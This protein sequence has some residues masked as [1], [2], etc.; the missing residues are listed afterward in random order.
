[1]TCLAIFFIELKYLFF[2][3]K[4]IILFPL[5]NLVYQFYIKPHLAKPA[6]GKVPNFLQSS[7]KNKF[8]LMS[9]ILNF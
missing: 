1:M 5:R 2:S 3:S 4:E 7:T 6:K 8:Y 9:K